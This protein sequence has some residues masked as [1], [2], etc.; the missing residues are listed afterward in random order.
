MKRNI[1]LMLIAVL[2]LM[3]AAVFA[4]DL[5][6]LQI[7]ASALLMSPV[8]LDGLSSF[9]PTSVSMDD[10]FI[11]GELRLNVSLFELSTLILPV[12]YGEYEGDYYVTGYAFP[13]IGI[14]L[15]LLG[16]VDVAATVGPYF[17]FAAIS[18][19]EFLTDISAGIEN[20]PVM[21]RLTADVNLGPV[22]VGAYLLVT[23][24]LRVGNLLDPDFNP[25]T[26]ALPSS[27][28][29]GLTAMVNLL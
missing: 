29:L 9:D 13:G 27:G 23:P 18:S 11:G 1:V 5:L 3:P 25:S 16:L 6:G 2:L 7:G 10:V 17:A 20:L 14:S 28:L 22:S 19:G 4:G 12:E 15:E 24:D 26:V 8:E 21:G